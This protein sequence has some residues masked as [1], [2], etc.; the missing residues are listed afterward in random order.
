MPTLPPTMP[1]PTQSTP[2]LTHPTLPMPHMLP[3]PQWKIIHK[4][5]NYLMVR[6][7][8]LLKVILL[9][10]DFIAKLM[11]SYAWSTSTAFTKFRAVL[12]IPVTVP[13]RSSGSEQNN[14][15]F[16]ML[17]VTGSRLQFWNPQNCRKG[18]LQMFRPA[19]SI[20]LSRCWVMVSLGVLVQK[21]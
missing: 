20:K 13:A 12:G 19:R 9:R 15:V 3:S 16:P 8:L 11:L 10:R 5:E 7:I 4:W 17:M 2:P 21:N 18:R 1:P 14:K 6:N